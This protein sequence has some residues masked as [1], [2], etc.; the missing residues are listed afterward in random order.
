MVRAFIA[1]QISESIQASIKQYQDKLKSRFDG[2][3]VRWVPV[4]NMHLTLKFLGDIESAQVYPILQ[5]LEQITSANASFEFRIE[6]FGCFPSFKRPR[7]LW[8]GI[9][10]SEDVLVKLQQDID[11]A[12]RGLGFEPERKRFHPH[13]TLGRVRKSARPDQLRAL[14]RQLESIERPVLGVVSAH[15]VYLIK[16]QLS[17]SGAQ[18]SHLGSA[19]MGRKS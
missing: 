2:A 8:L 15:A 19:A 6:G 17:P 13:L 12:L 5:V 14:S 11:D 3:G 4:E 18:Y 10:D 1:L 9:E 7:V 16:S